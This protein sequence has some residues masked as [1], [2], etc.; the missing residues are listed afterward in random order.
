VPDGERLGRYTLLRR[1]AS[2]G[3]GE[4]YLAAKAGP[5]GFG[6]RVALKVLKDDLANDAEFV[7]MLTDEAKISMVLSHQNIVSVLDLGE[8]R[9]RWFMAMEYVR[10]VTLQCLVDRLHAAGRPLEPPLALYVATELCRA[11]RY[12]HARVDEAGRPLQIVHRDVTPGNVL[13]STEGEVKLTDFGIA[14]ARGRIHA[15]RAGVVKGKFGYMAP[16]AVRGERGDHRADLFCLGVTLYL[17]LT[18]RHPVADCSVSEAV[19]RYEGGGV[20]PPTAV[21]MLPPGL[22]PIVMKALEPDPERRWSTAAEL[23]EALQ[24]CLLSSPAWRARATGARLAETVA[25]LAPETRTEPLDPGTLDAMWRRARDAAPGSLTDPGARPASPVELEAA[26]PSES[27]PPIAAANPD[28]EAPPAATGGGT[29]FDTGETLFEET[30][31][32]AGETLF[33]ETAFEPSGPLA[34]D[35]GAEPVD[36]RTIAVPPEVFIAREEGAGP[37]E[38]RT[39]AGARVEASDPLWSSERSDDDPPFAGAP[40]DDRTIAGVLAEDRTIAG[41]PG[42]DRP[43]A[44]PGGRAAEVEDGDPLAVGPD[45]AAE[46]A[47]AGAPPEPTWSGPTPADVDDATCVGLEAAEPT[48]VG[49]APVGGA[50]TDPDRGPRPGELSGSEEDAGGRAEEPTEYLPAVGARGEATEVSGGAGG[51]EAPRA[52]WARRRASGLPDLG[53]D[54][55]P[56][57]HGHRPPPAA[58]AG[59]AR[60]VPAAVPARSGRGGVAPDGWSDDDDARRLLAGRFDAPSG[61]PQSAPF[62]RAADPNRR[63]T[64]APGARAAGGLRDGPGRAEASRSVA[65]RRSG[66]ESGGGISGTGPGNAAPPP[67]TAGRRVGLGGAGGRALRWGLPA[68]LLAGGLAVAAFTD[69]LWPRLAIESEPPGAEVH[70]DGVPRGR[71]PVTVRVAP[72]TPHRIE[73]RKPGFAPAAREITGSTREG[74]TY[75]VR[76]RLEAVP[77]VYLAPPTAEVWVNGRRLGGGDA[78]RLK[79]L[80]AEGPVELEVRAAGHAAWSRTFPEASAVPE[81]FDVTLRPRGPRDAP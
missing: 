73:L 18:G 40:E 2:G 47:A 74:R 43:E 81:R 5:I 70:V 25:E 57:V 75:P 78:V 11:L 27:K 13:V 16:E 8:D 22:D 45:E 20:P 3:M 65:G 44:G 60:A 49:P 28:A 34:R 7:D 19:E 17:L 23:Q 48:R 77:T 30:P 69:V 33:E 52:P 31:L 66:G 61:T 36:D 14:R 63:S 15:T 64:P 6:S 58:A 35:D 67:E 24:A 80:P 55:P 38:N 21:T 26:R 46:G 54:E 62:G 71:T 9:G 29:P 39:D 1:I 56:D 4:V 51:L 76:V 10:G 37:P 12:A 79:D 50:A 68:L 41:I 42:D 32:D 59:R 53:E 72:R